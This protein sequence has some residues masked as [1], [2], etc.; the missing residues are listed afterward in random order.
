MQDQTLQPNLQKGSHLIV[1]RTG[2]DDVWLR[3]VE[4]DHPGGPPVP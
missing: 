4:P 2:G 3:G 1:K